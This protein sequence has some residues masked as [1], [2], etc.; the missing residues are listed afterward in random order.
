[1]ANT[2][3]SNSNNSRTFGVEF[4]LFFTNKGWA[5]FVYD[6]RDILVPEA[7]KLVYPEDKPSFMKAMNSG[8]PRKVENEIN[9]FMPDNYDIVELVLYKKLGFPKSW[10]TTSD[11]SINGGPSEAFSMEIVTP[12]LSIA[13][14]GLEAITKFCQA[15][16]P[17][18][19]V[20]KTTGLHVHVDA[21]E[22]VRKNELK[23]NL[24]H[25]LLIALMSYKSVEPLFDELVTAN[26]RGNRND[27]YAQATP[28]EAELYNLY[29][30]AILQD[31]N[32]LDYYINAFQYDRYNKLN[33]WSLEKHGTLEFRQMHGTLNEKLI[34]GWINIAINFVEQVLK[35]DAELK[36]YFVEQQKLAKQQYAQA[37]NDLHKQYPR[38]KMINTDLMIDDLLRNNERYWSNILKTPEDVKKAK[39]I[40]GAMKNG[41]IDQKVAVDYLKQMIAKNQKKLVPTRAYNQAKQAYQANP[42]AEEQE[43]EDISND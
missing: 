25:R 32:K 1:M 28:K 41:K 22:F 8:N 33:L 10:E 9:M 14:G 15:F 21:K 3:N 4:E 12:P 29:K 35:T 43:Q 34:T 20:N 5:Q 40:V 13:S 30:R 24:S 16:K 7:L 39:Q 17:Y 36:S 18:A 27:Q 6:N 2:N 26:R 19:S 31:S 11:M 42:L 23:K 38:T 37:K